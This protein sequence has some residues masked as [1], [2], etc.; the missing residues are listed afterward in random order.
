[1]LRQKNFILLQLRQL[2]VEII[3]G[4]RNVI[5]K[6]VGILKRDTSYRFEVEYTS[7]QL[8][9]ILVY[10]G[11]QL[12]RGLPVRLIING[13]GLIF[14]GRSV[15]IEHGYMIN[16][17]PNL[18]LEDNVSINA[19]SK[20]GIKFGRNVSIGK[21]VMIVCTGVIAHKGVGLEIGDDTG[22]N[23]QSYMGCQGGVK[24]GSNVIM[25]PGVRIFSENHNFQNIDRPIRV[26][27]VTRKE[28]VIEDDCW[29]GAGATLL[30]G[31]HV[32]RGSVIAAGSV[33]TKDVLPN[34]VVAGV[35]ASVIKHR[36]SN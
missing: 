15:H 12:L 23:A 2:T 30:A 6:I 34:T 19:L 8:I 16:S 31:V 28:V 10:R 11:I 3:M 7:R 4:L 17:G 1:V 20:N 29:I 33:V 36:N 13:S 26:Q 5:E 25:G 14:C 9:M 27:G 24:I 18:I 35:P 21:S 32:G 22:I